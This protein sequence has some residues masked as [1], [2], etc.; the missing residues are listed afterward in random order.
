MMLNSRSMR[1]TWQLCDAIYS[2]LYS[3]DFIPSN[4]STVKTAC[5][6]HYTFSGQGLHRFPLQWFHWTKFNLLKHQCG[7]LAAVPGLNGTRRE[8]DFIFESL[9]QLYVILI[10]GREI[11]WPNPQKPT[12]SRNL[13]MRIFKLPTT[14]LLDNIP[15]TLRLLRK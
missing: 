2:I 9:M 6:H 5:G 15:V 1:E 4:I 3:S 7:F 8:N 14:V 12:R 13:L 10:F 11:Q